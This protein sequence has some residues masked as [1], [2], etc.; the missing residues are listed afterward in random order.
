MVIDGITIR[1]SDLVPVWFEGYRIHFPSH[2]TDIAGFTG[3]D[4]NKC[5]LWAFGPS[6]YRLFSKQP[7][8]GQ[9]DI[10]KI[11]EAFRRAG[12]PADFLAYSN[13]DQAAIR[14]RLIECIVSRQ[15]DGGWRVNF[16]EAVML[17]ASE[18]EEPK[19]VFVVSV[20]GYIEFWFPDRLR[21]AMS[22]PPSNILL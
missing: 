21:K 13:D 8:D 5:L 11:A 7:T 19:F 15:G 14:A 4:Q 20:A 1:G 10:L 6:R 9:T 16:P 22:A 2:L 17:L 18:R 12:E 3:K